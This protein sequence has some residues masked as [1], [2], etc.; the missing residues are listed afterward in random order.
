MIIILLFIRFIPFHIIAYFSSPCGS[1]HI[2]T[3]FAH[4]SA[5]V[6]AECKVQN[7]ELTFFLL[8]IDNFNVL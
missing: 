8:A 5:K 1:A 6:N 2:L 4:I 7:A 3:F